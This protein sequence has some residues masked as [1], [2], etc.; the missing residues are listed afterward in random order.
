MI[1]IW[2]YYAS[3]SGFAEDGSSQA[4][5]ARAGE[6]YQGLSIIEQALVGEC[7]ATPSPLSFKLL[8]V[9]FW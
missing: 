2:A 8:L 4:G 7:K 9:V 6:I 1:Y 3:F 5:L